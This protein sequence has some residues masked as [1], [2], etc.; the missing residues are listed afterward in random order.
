M[1]KKA[2][3]FHEKGRLKRELRKGCFKGVFDMGF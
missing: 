3:F 1:L 2:L